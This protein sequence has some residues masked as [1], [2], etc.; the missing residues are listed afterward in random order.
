MTYL[1]RKCQSFTYFTCG[2]CLLFAQNINV[3]ENIISC[4][5]FLSKITLCSVSDYNNT[6]KNEPVTSIN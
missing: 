4:Q 6:E 3:G 2:A 5:T 1:E